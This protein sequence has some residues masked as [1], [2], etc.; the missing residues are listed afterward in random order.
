MVRKCLIYLAIAAITGQSVGCAG[1]KTVVRG[2]SHE[3][4]TANHRLRNKVMG[5]IDPVLIRAQRKAEPALK[6]TRK[7]L[8]YTGI[9]A[10]VGGLLYLNAWSDGEPEEDAANPAKKGHLPR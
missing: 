4:W 2:Q 1:N 8:A 9:A 5:K 3:T 6:T 7:V 10:L